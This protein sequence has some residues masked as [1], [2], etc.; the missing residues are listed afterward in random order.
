MLLLAN[1]AIYNCLCA[2]LQCTTEV[3]T[4][5]TGLILLQ[6]SNSADCALFISFNKTRFW[7]RTG[8]HPP[9]IHIFTGLIH[10][11]KR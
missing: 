5:G 1:N 7:V 2:W 3:I 4:K 10:T 6:Q 11:R 8:L 9:K